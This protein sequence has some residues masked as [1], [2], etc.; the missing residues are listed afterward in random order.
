MQRNIKSFGDLSRV[1][2]RDKLAFCA[3]VAD[4]GRAMHADDRRQMVRLAA[5]PLDD[6]V[7]RHAASLALPSGAVKGL[8]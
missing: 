3:A 7:N 8:P 6:L 1:M 5:G 4:D 2:R